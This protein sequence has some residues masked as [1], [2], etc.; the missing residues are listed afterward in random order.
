MNVGSDRMSSV[1]SH[2]VKVSPLMPFIMVFM[3]NLGSDLYLPATFRVN[4]WLCL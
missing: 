4:L 1:K 3:Y 2:V